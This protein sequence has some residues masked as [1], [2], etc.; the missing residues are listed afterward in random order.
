MKMTM[1]ASHF[2]YIRKKAWILD[3]DTICKGRKRTDNY[4]Y[5]HDMLFQVELKVESPVQKVV[6][7]QSDFKYLLCHRCLIVHQCER[8]FV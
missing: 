6:C 4:Y 5:M 3:D 7:V 1:K 2:P 8:I